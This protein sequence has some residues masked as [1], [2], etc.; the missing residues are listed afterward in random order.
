MKKFYGRIYS[1]TK[2]LIE[3][4]LILAKDVEEAAKGLISHMFLKVLREGDEYYP[5]DARWN[6]KPL[7]LA[8]KEGILVNAEVAN[9]EV[10]N[11]PELIEEFTREF[12]ERKKARKQK[13]LDAVIAG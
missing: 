6:V 13:T 9:L 3:E 11:A 1:P 4:Y 2:G 5:E 10:M 7:W 12:E 8:Y